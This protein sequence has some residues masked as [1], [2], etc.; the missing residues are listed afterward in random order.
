[1]NLTEVVESKGK[2]AADSGVKGKLAL[3]PAR[4]FAI[5]TRMHAQLDAAKFAGLVKGNAHVIRNAGGLASDDANWTLRPSV[6][7]VA[8]QL[9][10]GLE[11]GCYYLG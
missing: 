10:I 5:L 6:L 1:M 8:R 3:P 4:S 2:Y 11:S 7:R 9:K